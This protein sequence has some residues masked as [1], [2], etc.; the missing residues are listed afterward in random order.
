MEVETNGEA[1]ACTAPRDASPEDLA[2]VVR[3]LLGKEG[4]EINATDDRGLTPLHS[5]TFVHWPTEH[6]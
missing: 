4:I 6:C 2:D 3:L 5:F 1:P